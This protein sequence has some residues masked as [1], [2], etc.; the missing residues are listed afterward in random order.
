MF[1]TFS[2]TLSLSSVMS[3]SISVWVDNGRSAIVKEWKT[4]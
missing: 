4:I 1:I 3:T 2:N